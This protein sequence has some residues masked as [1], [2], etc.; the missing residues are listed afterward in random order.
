MK[1]QDHELTNI[2]ELRTEP[3]LIPTPA[4]EIKTI[5]DIPII[6]ISNTWILYLALPIDQSGINSL[7]PNDQDPNIIYTLDGNPVQPISQKDIDNAKR[8]TRLSVLK[9]FY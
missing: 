5:D 7:K 4:P 9:E 1:K 2:L 6:K 3:I 8:Q